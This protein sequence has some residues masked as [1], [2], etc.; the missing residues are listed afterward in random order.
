MADINLAWLAD[1][2]SGIPRTQAQQS[3]LAVQTTL[4]LP[5]PN[6]NEIPMIGLLTL[7][8]RYDKLLT[9]IPS[10]KPKFHYLPPDLD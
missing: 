3:K 10:L 4:V 1:R 5:K 6:S 8:T 7:P 2:F 9:R